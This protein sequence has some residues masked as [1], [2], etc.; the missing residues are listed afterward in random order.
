MI[1]KLCNDVDK[2]LYL[3]CTIFTR[4]SRV[5]RLIILKAKSG[6]IDKSFTKLLELCDVLDI[7]HSKSFKMHIMIFCTINEFLKYE[8]LCG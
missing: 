8:N 6:W 5:L 2:P 3:G 7:Y 4:L 1:N